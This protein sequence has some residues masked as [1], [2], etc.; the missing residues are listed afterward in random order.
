MASADT[1][2]NL[3]PALVAVAW[4]F[5]AVAVIVVAARFYV[6]RNIVHRLTLDDWI[7]LFTLVCTVFPCGR[8]LALHGLRLTFSGAYQLL[9]IGD[10][11][12]VT[13]AV[14]WGL[15]QHVGTLD[16]LHQMNSIKWVFL[17]EIFA[18][19]CPGFGRISYAILLLSIVTPTKSRQ[20]FLWTIIAVQFVV[21]VGTVIISMAQC[22]PIERF[23]DHSIEGSCWDVHVQQYTGFFQGCKRKMRHTRRPSQLIKG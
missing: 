2:E 17:C 10:S 3:G 12:F 8:F 15:G 19:M 9:A 23:W 7:I 11:I 22:Q 21:D 14:S 6:R 5:A 18:I 13:L 1:T 16:Q 20:V 4:V